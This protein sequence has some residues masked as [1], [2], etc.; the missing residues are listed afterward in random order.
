MEMIFRKDWNVL[1]L[2]AERGDADAQA[3]LGCYYEYGIK[4]KSGRL[5]TAANP[6]AAMKCYL[7]MLPPKTH[8][9]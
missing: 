4:D 8:W 3:A 1:R 9:G 7:A 5:L 2:A 6:V